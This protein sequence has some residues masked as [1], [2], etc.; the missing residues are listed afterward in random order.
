MSDIA[1]PFTL[2]LFLGTAA[3]FFTS[4]AHD[5]VGTGKGAGSAILEKEAAIQE[6][7]PGASA[8][9]SC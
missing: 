6:G 2:G 4:A 7:K 8:L 5:A 1:S 9:L 3:L